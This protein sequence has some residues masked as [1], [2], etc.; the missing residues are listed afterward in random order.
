M[1]ILSSN[2][3][4]IVELERVILRVNENAIVANIPGERWVLA[5]YPTPEDAE[6]VF[7]NLIEWYA[8]HPET[9]VYI[10]PD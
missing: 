3:K 10:L 1:L 7:N 4:G 5:E 9:R 2:K 6:K 8:D